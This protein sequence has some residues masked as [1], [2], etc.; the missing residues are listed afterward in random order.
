MGP[1]R[2]VAVLEHETVPVFADAREAGDYAGAWFS[3]EDAEA[4]LR[5]SET[6]SGF[7][8][9]V[10]SGMRL[11]QYCGVVPLP[12]C[13]LE[14]L[15]KLGL[16][17]DRGPGEAG[18]A[19]RALLAMLRRAGRLPLTSLDD[20]GQAL[21]RSF[22]L[23]VFVRA[24]LLCAIAQAR[25]GL[26]SRYVAHREDLSVV[27]GRFDARAH[28]RRNVARPHLVHCEYDEYTVD[29]PF[30]RAI[31]A[32]LG[33]CKPWITQ[34]RTEQ[35]W[36]EA[37]TRFENVAAIRM[38][39]QDV[40]ALRPLNRTTRRYDEV[41]TWC[42]NLLAFQS[43][44]L[45]AGRASAPGLLFDMNK[46]FEDHVASLLE[47]EAPA[48][49]LVRR[50]GPRLALA[51]CGAAQVFAMKPDVSVWH[52][53][54]SGSPAHVEQI[55]DAK[56]KRLK[57]DAD[58]LGADVSDIYQMLAYGARYGCEKL[59]LAYPVAEALSDAPP[60]SFEIL[61]ADRPVRVDVRLIPLWV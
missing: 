21:E 6:R 48:A 5:I 52:A 11:A 25:R 43:P 32:A 61:L 46:L 13:T 49:N 22:L 30:N 40:E 36:F 29:N 23:D 35:L 56:W 44:G 16:D 47:D 57:L 20:V 55:V 58:D 50:Q 2:V 8:R 3:E 12:S 26:L 51:R 27:R 31:L 53:D 33:A 34:S 9:R 54:R 19:R 17:A 10:A 15:P 24:F 42:V 38:K 7:C 60:K 1:S 41:L 59:T 28:F 45:R 37:R 39:A 18:R 4:L 14:V